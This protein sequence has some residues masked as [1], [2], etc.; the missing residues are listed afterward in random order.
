M[1]TGLAIVSYMLICNEFDETVTCD[2]DRSHGR[3]IGDFSM[4]TIDF[5]TSDNYE[6]TL[7]TVTNDLENDTNLSSDQAKETSGLFGNSTDTGNI[8]ANISAS[9][10]D[11]EACVED[12]LFSNCDTKGS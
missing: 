7:G 11:H 1:T 5:T 3:M 4:I 9:N 12:E 2:N 10:C 8:I 6:S